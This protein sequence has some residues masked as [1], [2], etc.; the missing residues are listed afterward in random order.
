MKAYILIQAEPGNDDRLVRAVRALEGISRVER[1]SGPYD[2]I[3]E[4]E[5]AMPADVVQRIREVD[6]VLRDT[7]LAG[8][9]R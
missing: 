1:V 9:G 7:H 6:G 8:P 4:A 5:W 2:L 3:A